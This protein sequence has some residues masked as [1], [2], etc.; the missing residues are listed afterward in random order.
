MIRRICLSFIAGLS[1]L[2]V[3]ASVGDM[4]DA[5]GFALRTQAGNT[6]DSYVV[7]LRDAGPRGRAS[8]AAEVT[9][10]ITG[11][12]G[13]RARYVFSSALNGFST[14][15]PRGV[16]EALSRD[17]RVQYVEQVQTVSI[18]TTQSPV[19][20]W[21]LDR[22]DQH[23]GLDSTYQ[24]NNGGSGVTA[25]VVD[26][27]ILISHNEFGG[28]AS[29][30]PNFDRRSGGAPTDCN[31]HGTAVAGIT[32]GATVGVAKSVSLVAVR[33]LG[34]DGFGFNDDVVAG[35]DWVTGDHQSRGTVAVANMSLGGGI[36]SALDD[37]LRNSIG[38]GVT[39][40]VAAGNS[41]NDVQFYSPS[42]VS[43]AIVVGSTMSNDQRAPDSNFGAGLDLFAPGYGIL[44]SDS[45]NNFAYGYGYGTSF[46][47]PFVTGV[48]ARLLEKMPWAPPAH[49][50]NWMTWQSTQG[51]VIDPGTGS[52]NQFLYSRVV[53]ENF[54]SRA[55]KDLTQWAALLMPPLRRLHQ[56]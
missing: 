55:L 9:Q 43:E 11:A 26:T 54:A 7:V 40:V 50:S 52:P 21:G 4:V 37:A 12:Y 53:D 14:Q 38:S 18:A 44:S 20:S 56:G 28:R 25:Y 30:G 33:V 10:R 31:G 42:H 36:S 48:A 35:I 13:I 15:V 49:I 16:A 24:Y 51:V 46:A 32:G 39:W 34:C 2:A 45:S 3:L 47:A 5:Q 1:S 41:N 29:Y 17:P 23:T 27:G 19:S 6:N 8:R 22:V